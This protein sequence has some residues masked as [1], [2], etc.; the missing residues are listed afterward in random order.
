VAAALPR[1][2]PSGEEGPIW[3]PRRPAQHRAGAKHRRPPAAVPIG[4]RAGAFHLSLPP[5]SKPSCTART[6]A[7]TEAAC[8]QRRIGRLAPGAWG[9]FC[10]TSTIKVRRC[11][12]LPRK[13]VR[14]A[15]AALGRP[16][17][18]RATG[19]TSKP[20][21]GGDHVHSEGGQC[22]TGQASARNGLTQARARRPGNRSS[23]HQKGA[24]PGQESGT[25]D[26][27]GSQPAAGWRDAWGWKA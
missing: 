17:R 24:M 9:G 16:G 26:H 8:Q 13:P 21:E 6:P 22:R 7:S 3:Q 27:P 4:R 15:Q 12:S 11:S 14:S 5:R 10:R 18:Q 1:W 20:R 25:C 19:A 23:A 2:P